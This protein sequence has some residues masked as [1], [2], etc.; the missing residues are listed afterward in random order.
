[1]SA[2]VFH[3]RRALLR[4]LEIQCENMHP[5]TYD[6][7]ADDMYDQGMAPLTKAEFTY[8]MWF[9]D[10]KNMIS[11]FTFGISK[12]SYTDYTGYTTIHYDWKWRPNE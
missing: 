9:Y 1:M 5:W 8:W 6:I 4:W 7:Y 2:S 12:H 3:M 10:R 11:P